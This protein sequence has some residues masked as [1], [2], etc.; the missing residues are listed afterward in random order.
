MVTCGVVAID[1]V[2]VDVLFA[3]DLEVIGIGVKVGMGLVVV[4]IIVV[5]DVVVISLVVV[6]NKM[7]PFKNSNNSGNNSTS[8]LQRNYIQTLSYI[9]KYL[10]TIA[11]IDI[12]VLL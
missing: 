11:V 9:F 6:V 1:E 8:F 5:V 7:S 10:K 12:W 3:V 2:T 4:G